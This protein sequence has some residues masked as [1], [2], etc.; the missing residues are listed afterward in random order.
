MYSGGGGQASWL[1]LYRFPANRY[2]D[3]MMSEVL[4]VPIDASIMIR[5]CFAEKDMALRR[6][7]CHDLYDFDATLTL[8]ITAIGAPPVLIYQTKATAEPGNS[9]RSGDNS[10]TQ[11]SAADILLRTDA[12][13]SYRRELTMNPV[14]GRYEFD[15]PGPDCS[16]YTVP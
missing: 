7:A 12:R 16:E 9:R 15:R 2:G 13:C 8:G 3:P 10:G 1:S 11:L 6:G 5:A 4:G 14:T